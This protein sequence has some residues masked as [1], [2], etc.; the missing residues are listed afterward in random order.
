MK[1]FYKA[2]LFD[3][4]KNLLTKTQQSYL[5]DYYVLDLSLGEIAENNGISRQSVN[6]AIKKATKQLERYETALRIKEKSDKI[7]QSIK[8][9]Q[10]KDV[11][12]IVESILND[13]V[14]N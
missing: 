12:D 14:E 2:E 9:V 11:I 1:D 8:N 3:I 13:S 6:D 10:N 4:Y 7:K 5:Y